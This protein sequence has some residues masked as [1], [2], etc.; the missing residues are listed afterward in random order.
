MGLPDTGGSTGHKFSRASEAAAAIVLFVC[1]PVFFLFE[2]CIV[3][4]SDRNW[5]IINKSR[6]SAALPRGRPMVS[7]PPVPSSADPWWSLESRAPARCDRTAPRGSG[8]A[9]AQRS[10]APP[11]GSPGTGTGGRWPCAGQ[12]WGS[13]GLWRDREDRQG[14]CTL[15]SLLNLQFDFTIWSHVLY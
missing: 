15:M 3:I 8:R 1:L 9:A 4:V 12:T 14:W 13:S 5:R 11:G 7:T 10:G 6:S 2:M